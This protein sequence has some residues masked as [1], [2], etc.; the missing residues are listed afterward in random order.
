MDGG[1]NST[2]NGVS[3]SPI[4]VY[5][6]KYLSIA[7]ICQVF[8]QHGH[9]RN[10]GD[11]R[12]KLLSQ[13]NYNY[14]LIDRCIL[15]NTLSLLVCLSRKYFGSILFLLRLTEYLQRYGFFFFLSW[16]VFFTLIKVIDPVQSKRVGGLK[17]I[18]LF[19]SIFWDC[20]LYCNVIIEVLKINIKWYFL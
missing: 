2:S 19:S 15:F 1:K 8:V 16:W 7:H 5:L 18:I 4:L 11:C 6:A 17:E 14:L 20:T 10:P 12:K 9:W 13:R 3:W